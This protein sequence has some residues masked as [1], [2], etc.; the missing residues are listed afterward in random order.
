MET[1]VPVATGQRVPALA[2]VVEAC[3]PGDQDSPT[4]PL[5]VVDALQEIP[6]A[7]VLV[8]LVEEQQRFPGRQLGTSYPWW[9]AGMIPIQ[10]RGV[11]FVGVLAEQGKRERRLAHLSRATDEHHLLR[12]RRGHGCFEVAGNSH[13]VDYS[14]LY[15]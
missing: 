3:G 13:I 14:P 4:G 10:I 8:D 15:S 9:D 5:R 11:P 6:P 7:R 1:E 2:V 12:Q